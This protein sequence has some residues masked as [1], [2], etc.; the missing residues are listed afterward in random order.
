MNTYYSC[1]AA[2]HSAEH[3]L[4]PGTALHCTALHCTALHCTALHCTALHCTAH[5][6]HLP[7]KNCMRIFSQRGGQGTEAAAD[8]DYSAAAH[9]LGTIVGHKTFR[10]KKNTRLQAGVY[11]YIHN[12]VASVQMYILFIIYSLLVSKSARSYNPN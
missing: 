11:L 10:I 12:A 9:T 5:G 3:T 7:V 6:R 1:A 8:V 2:V 4:H